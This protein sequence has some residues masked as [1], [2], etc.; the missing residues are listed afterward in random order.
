MQP[1]GDSGDSSSE[2][3]EEEEDEDDSSVGS[4]DAEEQA[5]L[6]QVEKSIPTDNNHISRRQ[7]TQPPLLQRTSRP[8]RGGSA[9]IERS[10]SRAS[11]QHSGY[12]SMMTAPS[13]LRRLSQSSSSAR[14]VNLRPVSVASNRS[15]N[16]T[17]NNARPAR[18]LYDENFDDSVNPWDLHPSA[19]QYKIDVNNNNNI[20]ATSRSNS[21]QPSEIGNIY[22]SPIST[23]SSVTATQYNNS[24][25]TERYALGRPISE[26]QQQMQLGP[27]TKR[28]LESIQH[29]I[30]ALNER[31]NG[32]RKEIVDRDR[33][34]RKSTNLS[35]AKRSDFPL[36]EDGWRWVFKVSTTAAM[37]AW[38]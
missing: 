7:Q 20:P 35:P 28:A 10:S 16:R 21:T 1:S 6:R 25:T 27:A 12:M 2:E 36:P 4:E 30:E 5:Y 17:T 37:R 23:S 19:R 9:G 24:V 11:S 33:S 13:E 32:L 8:W 3:E 38:L 31:I 34:I 15:N 18:E 29:E 26:Q 14:S 22:R